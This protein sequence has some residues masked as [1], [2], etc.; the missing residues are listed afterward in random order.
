M[1]INAMEAAQKK[2][3]LIKAINKGYDNWF[4]RDFIIS[5]YQKSMY[6]NWGYWNDKTRNVK[7]ACDNLV[8]TLMQFIEDKQGNILEVACGA[9]GVTKRLC[10]Y[11]DPSDISAINISKIQL[12]E[13]QKNAPGCN[14]MLMDATELNFQDNA[15]DNMISVEAAFHF[16]TRIKFFNEAYRVLRPG[17]KLLMSDILFSSSFFSHLGKGLKK[18]FLPN[19]KRAAL[20]RNR[21]KIK[22]TRTSIKTDYMQNEYVNMEEYKNLLID[23]GFKDVMLADIT[24]DTFIKYVGSMIKTIPQ[25]ANGAIGKSINAFLYCIQFYSYFNTVAPIDKYLLISATK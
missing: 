2:Q 7:E 3:K 23:A 18:H 5:Y 17:G 11:Y 13:A 4:N 8:D 9:G 20:N 16:N 19:S 14:F 15:F 25:Y 6:M 24:K 12:R 21:V 22:K 10:N 1:S